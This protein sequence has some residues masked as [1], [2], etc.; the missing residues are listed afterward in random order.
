M[1]EAELSVV[2]AGEHERLL[3]RR[4]ER[5]HRGAAL[6][7]P[8]LTGERVIAL[9]GRLA[10]VPGAERDRIGAVLGDPVATAATEPRAASAVVEAGLEAP[11]HRHG[12]AEAF[13][14][15]AELAQ[16]REVVAVLEV[17]RVGQ[18]HRTVRR[19][20]GRFEHVR[21][22]QVAPAG[23]VRHGWLQLERPAAAG[24]QDPREDRG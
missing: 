19:L 10:G 22:R 12:A 1:L 16:R 13:D 3:V 23:V 2:A 5:E 11:A 9:E 20:E 24:V 4:G 14:L 6:F 17:H 15:A 8:K 18:A 21:A 7:E